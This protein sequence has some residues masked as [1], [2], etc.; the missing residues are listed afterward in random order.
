MMENPELK[1]T[2]PAKVNHPGG[3]LVF[4]CSY[5]SYFVKISIISLLVFLLLVITVR[6]YGQA[7]SVKGRVTADKHKPAGFINITL[8]KDSLQ[9][10]KTITDTTGMFILKAVKGNYI[11]T[12]S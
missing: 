11:L 10:I 5:Q 4:C 1:I 8:K 7:F 12:L 3:M 6:G 9:S 2:G